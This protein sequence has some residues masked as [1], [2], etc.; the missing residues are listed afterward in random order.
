M[1]MKILFT[2]CQ[3]GVAGSTHSIYYLI[4]GLSQKGHEIHLACG[5]GA[6]LWNLVSDL[7]NVYC[8]DVPFDS[9]LDFG[10]VRSIVRVIKKHQIELIN[11]QGGKDRNLTILAKWTF[12]LD[13]KIVFTR[14]QR[15]RNEPWIKRWFHTMGTSGI[16]MVSEGLKD[17]FLKKGYRE[18]HLKVIFNGVPRDLLLQVSKERVEGL[19][20]GYGLVGKIICCVSRKKL[21]GE[22]IEALK[23]LPE[24]YNIL[25]VGIAQEDFA[26]LL[27]REG[28]KQRIIFTGV[29]SHELALHYLQLADVN[30]LPSHMDGFGLALVE[31]MLCR[32]AVIGSRF[33]GIP[34]IIQDGVNGFLFNN[35]ESEDLAMKIQRLVESQTLR[36]RFADK[37]FKDATEKFLVERTV[38]EYEAYF[39]R[40]VG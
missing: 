33:G 3:G 2:T 34:D 6:L 24:D 16:V 9:Y 4:R 5:K 7:G 20:E 25:F 12:A 10:S 26:E 31:A 14:R 8:H 32:V 38:L 19:R 15:P 29:V 39:R 17:I 1:A 36:K 22:L 37:A 18:A 21:Q 23:Y 27:A 30:I 28:P 11:A 40:L 13:V 35:G